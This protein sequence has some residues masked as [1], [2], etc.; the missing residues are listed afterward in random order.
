MNKLIALWSAILIANLSS[1][2][3]ILPLQ[4]A[5]KI[6]RLVV[7][8]IR[9]TNDLPLSLEINVEK[10]QAL[11][12]GEVGI[13]V[14]PATRLSEET[15]SKADKDVTPLGQ[16]WM[17]KALPARNGKVTAREKL[18]L[19]EVTDDGK[20]VKVPL[21][22]L[23]ARRSEKGSLELLIYAKDKAPLLE[24][25][26]EKTDARQEFPIELQGRKQDDTSGILT[27]NIL[28]KYKVE[29][30]VMKPED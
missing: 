21:F 29:L 24:L 22:L 19:V 3:E 26:M 14:I 11:K 28:G 9:A 10:P 4:Q 25:P 8:S 2:Q 16:L 18:R 12:A 1:A 7:K 6:A 20:E 30:T 15:L 13:L 17:L 23:G 27:L 5:Q